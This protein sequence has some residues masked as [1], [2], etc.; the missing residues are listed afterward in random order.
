MFLCSQLPEFFSGDRWLQPSG[1]QAPWE[2]LLRD[3]RPTTPI[4]AIMSPATEQTHHSVSWNPSHIVWR[5]PS[6]CTFKC[7]WL[8]DQLESSPHVPA[9]T[10]IN[11][12]LGAS[13]LWFTISFSL[14]LG[15]DIN[16]LPHGVV[17]KMNICKMHRR[18]LGT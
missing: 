5:Q 13:C 14:K 15:S 18:E 8:R 11:P 9:S 1:I 12:V 2:G 17:A 3:P 16:T 7:P 10:I 4:F 6:L